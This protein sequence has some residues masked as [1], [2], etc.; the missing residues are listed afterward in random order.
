[1]KHL[2]NQPPG[3]VG[4]GTFAGIGQHEA[5]GQVAIKFVGRVSIIKRQELV[6]TKGAAAIKLSRKVVGFQ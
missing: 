6:K 4:V 2:V 1:M 5:R 3:F